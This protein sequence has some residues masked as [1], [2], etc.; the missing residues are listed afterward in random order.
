[1]ASRPT[2]H[3]PR[4]A[5]RLTVPRPDA[6]RATPSAAIPS[7]S[8]FGTRRMRRSTSA[9]VPAQAATTATTM[10]LK[11]GSTGS[12]RLP[13]DRVEHVAC[14]CHGHNRADGDQHGQQAVFHEILAV[15]FANQTADG[16]KQASHLWSSPIQ[17]ERGAGQARPTRVIERTCYAGSG[18]AAAMAV[19]TAL[20]WVPAAA[21]AVTQ[22]S[23][24]NAMSNA[25]S[26]RSC[27]ESSRTSER[28]RVT[29]SLMVRSSARQLPTRIAVCAKRRD[30]A[31]LPD[32]VIR[33]GATGVPRPTT[34]T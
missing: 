7:V 21:T 2:A 30:Q 27:P 31:T 25:Y 15:V 23:A 33:L 20:T 5:H 10:G 32:R 24:I 18:I 6:A 13:Q 22:A 11:A 14:R 17:S 1:M 3:P 9:L 16:D 26:S 4:A 8:G 19:N 34:H 28:K 12:N 29:T